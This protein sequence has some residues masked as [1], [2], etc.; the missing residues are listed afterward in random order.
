MTNL[1]EH[2]DKRY[3]YPTTAD[4]CFSGGVCWPRLQG[5]LQH[6]WPTGVRLWGD[7]AGGHSLPR[8]GLGHH[9]VRDHSALLGWLVTQLVSVFLNI[10]C[11]FKYFVCF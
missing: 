3:F 7:F 4:I 9:P 10:Y 2:D 1:T 5:H 8:Q 11:I 6:V